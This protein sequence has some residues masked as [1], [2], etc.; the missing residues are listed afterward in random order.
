[1]LVDRHRV[2]AVIALSQV[3]EAERAEREGD[4]DDAVARAVELGARRVNE[5]HTAFTR[6]EVLADPEGNLLELLDRSAGTAEAVQHLDPGDV[7]Q[8]DVEDEDVRLE[9]LGQGQALVAVR[10]GTQHAVGPAG[11]EHL[12]DQLADGRLIFHDHDGF[13]GK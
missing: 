1:M 3:P 4:L 9:L 7:G 12:D 10:G 6:F 13:R 8:E 2:A 5:Q 11:F